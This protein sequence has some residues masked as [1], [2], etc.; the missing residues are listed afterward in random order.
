VAG[1]ERLPDP[2]A[3]ANQGRG[4]LQRLLGATSLEVFFEQIW[5]R[6]HLFIPSSGGRTYDEL[7]PSSEL[8][9]FFSRNDVR[10]PSVQ[11]VKE[12]R[13][14]ALGKYAR[15]LKIGSYR[16]DGLIDMDLVAEAYRKGS[17]ILVQLMQNSFVGLAEFAEALRCFFRSKIDVHAFLT[18]PNAQGLKAHYDAAS[19]F[20]IQLRGAKQWRL[21][22][23]QVEAPAQ[24]F[25]ASR[26]ITGSP[27][28]EVTLGQGDV[29]Y[30]PRGLPHEGVTLDAESVHL[31]VVLFPPSWLEILSSV[32]KECQKDE[33]F[34][35]A[36]SELVTNSFAGPGPTGTWTTLVQQ[37]TAQA[38]SDA[39]LETVAAPHVISPRSRRGRWIEIS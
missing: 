13:N 15:Q 24:S 31:T 37:F 34:R 36:P 2:L 23:M 3:L 22:E 5:E 14:V 1:N 8:D 33:G 18:P 25:D 12:G 4:W 20:L 32:L 28:A 6:K 27:I 39:W 35:M 29:L 10:F 21:Y 7:L 19:A 17:T 9:A 26:P 30:L 11:V 16:S 38:K